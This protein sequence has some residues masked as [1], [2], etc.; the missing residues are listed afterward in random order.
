M[1]YAGGHPPEIWLPEQRKRAG[2]VVRCGHLPVEDTLTVSG[3]PTTSAVRGAVDLARFV[4]NDEAIVGIDQYIRRDR[5]GN[6]ITTRRQ[7]LA[8][9]DEHPGLY[10]ANRVRAVLDES[11]TGSQ[12]PWETYSRLV[13]HRSGLDFFR[14]QQPVPGTPYH[15]DLG[16]ARYRVAIEYDGG[17]HRTDEQQRADVIRWNAI[18]GQGWGL[19][20]ATSP[21]LLTGR[22]EFLDRVERELRTR[23]WSGPSP[24]TPKLAL[25]SRPTRRTRLD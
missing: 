24:T 16:S 14:T 7:I 15:V 11:D 5:G 20:R 12:S 17:Y 8:Y 22:A 9:L 3:W 10:G 25:P 19:I 21:T 23:G 6:S 2:V 13:V 4:R 18:T 1:P